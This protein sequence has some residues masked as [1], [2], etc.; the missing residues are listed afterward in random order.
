MSHRCHI[1]AYSINKCV[2]GSLVIKNTIIFLQL[3]C[4]SRNIYAYYTGPALF[5]QFHL[6]LSET[7]RAHKRWC[8]TAR[9]LYILNQR[10]FKGSAANPLLAILSSFFFF[11][12]SVNRLHLLL[13]VSI[14]A[15]RGWE[16]CKHARRVMQMCEPGLD[17]W[18]S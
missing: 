11:H 13:V 10:Y 16:A 14:S 4:S 15:L 5:I 7:P 9:K 6:E 18:E 12:I 8:I 17:Q 1:T 3:A 2:V